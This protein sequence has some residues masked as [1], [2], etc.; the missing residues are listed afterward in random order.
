MILQRE[1][2]KPKE[3]GRAAE[4]ETR[5]AGGKERGKGG[6]RLSRN[7]DK[8]GERHDRARAGGLMELVCSLLVHQWAT[9]ARQA[10]SCSNRLI[11]VL[12][13]RRAGE[14]GQG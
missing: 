14:R 13:C 9:W 7:S 3:G 12:N 2:D 6:D 4:R 10:H 8:A 5:R 11:S 1:A